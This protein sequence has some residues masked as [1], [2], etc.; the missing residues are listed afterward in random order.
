MQVA[1]QNLLTGVEGA[2]L[3]DTG[4]GK[5]SVVGAMLTTRRVLVVSATLSV[6]VA[7]GVA[8]TEASPTSLLWMG[9]ALL[10]TTSSN[11]V[12]LLETLLPRSEVV[13]KNNTTDS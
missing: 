8:S 5:A 4:E 11:Q 13:T 9:P 6:L 3:D 12:C 10:F 2:V 1:W 7:F